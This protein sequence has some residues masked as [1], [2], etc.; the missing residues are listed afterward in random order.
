VA[1]LEPKTTPDIY[2]AA[3]VDGIDLNND[4]ALAEVLIQAGH[5][6]KGLI[7]ATQDPA[8]K[9]QLRGNTE[10]AAAA[11]ACGAPTIMI[12]SQ[13]F[14]GQDRLNRVGEALMLERPVEVQAPTIKA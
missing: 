8:I 9:A 12:G 7:A 10:A 6:G 2:K 13:V 5:D 1:I 11:G 4:E 3:W 14:W